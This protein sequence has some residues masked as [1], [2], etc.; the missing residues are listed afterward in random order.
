[1]SL[2]MRPH[3]PVMLNEILKI[4]QKNKK[5]IIVDCTFGCGGYSN[6]ILE[7]FPQNKIIA[8][9]RDIEVKKFAKELEKKYFKRFFFHK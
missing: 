3:Y 1:M 9:D 6:K 7:F 4:L 8:I 5:K 2:D